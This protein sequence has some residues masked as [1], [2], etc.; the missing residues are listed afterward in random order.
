MALASVGEPR[1]AIDARLAG[2]DVVL[3]VEEDA[4][5]DVE[6][7]AA[8]CSAAKL[9]AHRAALQRDVTRRAA[10]EVAG[11]ASSVAMAAQLMSTEQPR[12]ADQLLELAARGAQLAW[13]AGRC[14]RSGAAPVT[15]VD[16]VAV[17]RSWCRSGDL[18]GVSSTLDPESAASAYVLADPVG[19]MRCMTAIFDSARAS[20]C[21]SIVAQVRHPPAG[22]SVE[23]VL[24]DDGHGR[25]CD[26]TR[27]T[28]LRREALGLAESV[29]FA[30]DH[31]GGLSQS[32]RSDRRGTVTSLWLPAAHV[33]ASSHP[34]PPSTA[35]DTDWAIARIL[36]GIARRDP[37]ER[38][39][40]ALVAIME[41]H[42]P[43]SVCSILLLDE[44]TNTLR[45]GAG[46]HLP[47]PYRS[48]IDGVQ[49]GPA[50]GSCGTAAFIR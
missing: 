21:T 2:A 16:V 38:S 25:P 35:G 5:P 37:V 18:H 36:E 42:L 48:A 44:A 4:V 41:Q 13:D 49:I 50:V 32:S 43:H 28:A 14:A 26:S 20:E 1:D 47:A 31:G 9:L 17:L 29:E 15:L 27:D 8:A 7:L 45:H 19:F 12:R 3:P 46:R 39:L 30:D 10:H 11:N 24:T 33:E 22:E 34:S 6:D 23:I 40:E